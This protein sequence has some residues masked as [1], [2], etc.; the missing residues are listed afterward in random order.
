ME[1]APVRDT[2]DTLPGSIIGK[3]VERLES[4]PDRYSPSYIAQIISKSIADKD[5]KQY[6][7]SRGV[8]KGH[9]LE[10]GQDKLFMW[11]PR[12]A[13]S[14]IKGEY[15]LDYA[16]MSFPGFTHGREIFATLDEKVSSIPLETLGEDTIFRLAAFLTI[17]VASNHAF[18]DANGRVAV[19]LADVFLRR[20]ARK[21]VDYEKLDARAGELRRA[22]TDAT[23]SLLPGR[24]N[25]ASA[26]ARM[27]RTEIH[28]ETISVP[29]VTVNAP[30][31]KQF[32]RDF[33][34]SIQQFIRDFDLARKKTDPLSTYSHIDKIAAI[35]REAS[36]STNQDNAK[37]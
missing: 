15:R 6:G 9:F 31:L 33:S 10:A 21:A 8:R 5:Q 27:E 25:P 2:V 14:I 29:G 3:L 35:Y 16:G 12:T 37:S 26:F 32:L 4:R 28:R 13:L 36:V 24:Y 30:Q 7:A 20:L 34:G 22:M 1:R 18:P 23:C 19:G 17:V 11:V